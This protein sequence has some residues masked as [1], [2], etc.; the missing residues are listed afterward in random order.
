[1]NKNVNP[2]FEIDDIEWTMRNTK[3]KNQGDDKKKEKE[4]QLRG[5]YV[6]TPY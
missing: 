1:M 6:L 3:V 2:L 4:R 5:I